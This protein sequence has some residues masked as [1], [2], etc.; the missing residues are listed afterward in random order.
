MTDD[1]DP[2]LVE[3][4][5]RKL[6]SHCGLMEQAYA[7]RHPP[8]PVEAREMDRKAAVDILRAAFEPQPI[9][10]ALRTEGGG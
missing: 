2:A 3:R 4:V 6:Q 10:T 8:T 1:F 5:T 9:E 7:Q